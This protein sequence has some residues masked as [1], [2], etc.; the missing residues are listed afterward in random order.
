MIDPFDPHVGGIGGGRIIPVRKKKSKSKSPCRSKAKNPYQTRV[1][2]AIS[3]NIDVFGIL[4][5]VAKTEG[6]FAAPE[7]ALKA[8]IA[9]FTQDAWLVLLK[10]S[11]NQSRNSCLLFIR[12]TKV[13]GMLAIS[14]LAT[15]H[16]SIL[17][18]ELHTVVLALVYE[19]KNLRSTVARSAI[20]T[21]GDLFVK[22]KKTIEPVS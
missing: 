19:V 7:E 1:T 16:P 11:L 14:R 21:L 18:K 4:E 20:F 8:S 12:T 17:A 13:E 3:P 2:P 10:H 22:M 15:F 6:A 9:A 5:N